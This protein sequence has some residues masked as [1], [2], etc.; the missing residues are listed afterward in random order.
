MIDS[1]KTEWKKFD[2]IPLGG[3]MKSTKEAVPIDDGANGKSGP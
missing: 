2:C 1:E 3:I